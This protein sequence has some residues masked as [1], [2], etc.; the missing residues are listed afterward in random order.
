M[1]RHYLCVISF[2]KIEEHFK[3]FLPDLVKIKYIHLK[4]MEGLLKQS[5]I[6]HS[7]F[8][9]KMGNWPGHYIAK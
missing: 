5:T 4:K 6:Y 9:N 7:P 8:N 2:I 3:S 1:F